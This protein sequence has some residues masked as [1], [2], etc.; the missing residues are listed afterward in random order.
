MLNIVLW[1]LGI[2]LIA[3][4]YA[5]ARGPWAR[6]QAL[7]EE[8]AN[9][10]RYNAW[11]GGVRDTSTTGASVAMQLYRRQARVGATIAAAGALLVVLGFLIK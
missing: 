2:A 6:Y 11:R 10:S 3:A 7:R 4:G 8:D 1:T 9:E 5:R